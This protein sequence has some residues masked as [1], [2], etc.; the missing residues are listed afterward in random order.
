MGDGRGHERAE[1]LAAPLPLAGWTSVPSCADSASGTWDRTWDPSRSMK[2]ILASS[3]GPQPASMTDC[4]RAPFAGSVAT[5]QALVPTGG[6]PG[7]QDCTDYAV[8]AS[9][10]RP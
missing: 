3:A 7:D 4:P 2:K 1:P 8:S 9:L 6:F 10:T 5:M